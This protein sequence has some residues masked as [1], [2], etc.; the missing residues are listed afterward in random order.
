MMTSHF[1]INLI[2]KLSSAKE[3]TTSTDAVWPFAGWF[4]TRI[5]K[6]KR[7]WMDFQETWMEDWYKLSVQFNFF[8]S[9][10]WFLRESYKVDL[11]E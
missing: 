1:K 9:L 5:T 2:G 10:S 11:D 3:I 7:N 4:V 6:N 8:P